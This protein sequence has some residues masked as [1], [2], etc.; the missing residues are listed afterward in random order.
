[1]K[2]QATV[3]ID[4]DPGIDD[5]LALGYAFAHPQVE[6]AALIASGGN[7]STENVGR[8]L[9][10]IMQLCQETNIEWALGARNPLAQELKTTEETHGGLGVGYAKLPRQNEPTGKALG[11][12]A[13]LWVETA[14]RYSGKLDAIVLGPMTN[15]ALALEL[16]PELPQHLRSLTIMGGALNHRGNT[17]PTTEWNVHSDP[18]AAHQ[19]FAAFS[20]TNLPV[21]PTLCPLDYTEQMEM[22][23]QLRAKLCEGSNPVLGAMNDALEFYMEFHAD[24]GYGFIAH[25]HDPFAT[26]YAITRSLTE[27]GDTNQPQLAS[28]QT[29]CID[30]ELTGKLTRGQTIADWSGR[31]NRPH[32]AQVLASVQPQEFFQH[33]TKIVR[34]RFAA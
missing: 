18:E 21:Y 9:R 14:R 1:M 17:M 27:Q 31:W 22:T 29:T 23:P 28:T 13:Q 12:G 8:N 6:I 32:N 20:D 10:G 2:T 26:A 15:L 34:D 16:D 7:V 33:Y 25:V 30:V 11:E 5:F 3:L 4:C 19:V 24:D